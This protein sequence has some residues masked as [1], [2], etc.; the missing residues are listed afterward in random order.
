MKRTLLDG[1]CAEVVEML[2]DQH[3]NGHVMRHLSKMKPARQIKAVDLMLAL[4]NFTAN[5]AAAL[6]AATP[7]A[8]LLD[9]EKPN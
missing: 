8:Q 2:K 9:P 4:Y 5:Y 1:I 3:V 6:L 7:A